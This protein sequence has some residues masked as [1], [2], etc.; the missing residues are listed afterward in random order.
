MLDVFNN[1]AF[2]MVSLTTA[3]NKLP[4]VPG[5]LGSL[6][7]FSSKGITTTA[8]VVEEKHGV[9]SLVPAAARGTMPNA[10]DRAA[11]NARS[12]ICP[13]FPQNEGI[14]ADDVQNVRAFGSETAVETVAQ[15]VNDQLQSM[16]NNFEAT[17]EFQRCGA[18]R[19]VTY[20]AD[21][22][23]EIYNF[24]DEF[25]LTETTAEW[26]LS[27]DTFDTKGAC[28]D[29]AVAMEDALGATPYTGIVGICSLSFWK[30]LVS[31]ATVQN[32]YD[33]WQDGRFLRDSQLNTGF[34]YGG[35]TWHRYRGKVG[36]VEF[37]PADTCRFAPTGVPDLFQQVN[38]PGTF[39][40]TVNTIGQP[41]YA[42]QERMKFDVGVELHSQSNALFLPSRPAACI[43]GTLA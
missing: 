27:D 20:D 41:M 18:L 25:D 34:E 37:I 3:L 2:N 8:A 24:F 42:K 22:T 19:G 32:A 7:L 9:L 40:E 28:D 35:I 17:W 4:Y 23:T 11:R 36:D 21:G 13:H 5:L 15:L 39:V 12:F 1:D 33:R 14:M 43:E 38:A 10:N 6:G 29:T 16:R 26:T 30:A 31:H